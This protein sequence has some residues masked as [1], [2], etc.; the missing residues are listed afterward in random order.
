MR[1]ESRKL[2]KDMLGAATAINEFTDGKTW[3]DFASS[4]L[5]RSG[6]ERQFEIVG[7][8]LT[9][10]LKGDP[11]TGRRISDFR[12]IVSFRN[13]LIHGYS[14][15]NDAVTGKV[16]QED[17]PV[18]MKELADLLGESQSTESKDNDA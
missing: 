16:V 8:A 11:E 1:L 18:L 13:V 3:D 4:R 7:E 12:R 10:L 15:V 9:V 5:L 6:V 17:L 2:L 14:K